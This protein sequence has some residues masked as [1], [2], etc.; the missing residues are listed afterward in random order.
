MRAHE[1]SNDVCMDESFFKN[2]A[3]FNKNKKK[4]ELSILI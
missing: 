2:T 4:H 3:V 1:K